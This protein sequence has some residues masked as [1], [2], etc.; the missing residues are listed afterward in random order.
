MN[1]SALGKLCRVKPQ[2]SNN[3]ERVCQ[4]LSY[5]ILL[6]LRDQLF[7][8]CCYLTTLYNELGCT[9]QINQKLTREEVK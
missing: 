1:G 6:F 3:K 4:N 2:R 5:D 7:I 8:S 9:A